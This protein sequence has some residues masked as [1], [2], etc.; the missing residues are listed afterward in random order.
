M[1]HWKVK[2]FEH[3]ENPYDLECKINRFIEENKQIIDFDVKYTTVLKEC[4]WRQVFFYSAI[5]IY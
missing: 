5:I 2:F 3:Q 1:K 4:F